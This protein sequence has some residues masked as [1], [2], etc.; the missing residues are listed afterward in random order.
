MAVETKPCEYCG[1][2]GEIEGETCSW[3][4]GSGTQP[5]RSDAHDQ[6]EWN[7]KHA[8]DKIEELETKIEAIAVQVQALFD[9]LNP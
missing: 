8:V 2:D 4:E 6:A 3:C 1:G 9:D 7:I 5:L